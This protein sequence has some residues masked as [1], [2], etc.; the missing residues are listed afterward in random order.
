[1]VMDAKRIHVD[2]MR[3]VESVAL[4]A[5]R[6]SKESR[7]RDLQPFH[8]LADRLMG[9]PLLLKLAA[10]VIGARLE[11]NDTLEGALDYVSRAYE[12]RGLTAFDPKDAD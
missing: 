2:E 9:W 7:P 8:R 6:V 3:P 5:T 12:K 10:G 11:R 1:M 4:L